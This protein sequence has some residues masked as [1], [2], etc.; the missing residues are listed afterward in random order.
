MTHTLESL[1]ALA[2]E[3]RTD[4]YFALESALLKAL[5]DEYRRGT[6]AAAKEA[7]TLREALWKACGDDEETVNSYIASVS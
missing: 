3:L 5:R 7:F 6:D 4:E 1:M 2:T